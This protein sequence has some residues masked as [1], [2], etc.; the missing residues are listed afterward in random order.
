M[1]INRHATR[2]ILTVVGK[3]ELAGERAGG[4]AIG[5]SRMIGVAL[6]GSTRFARWRPVY[7]DQT[8]HPT[9]DAAM[10]RELLAR[11]C[12]LPSS[13]R[14]LLIVLTEYRHALHGLA[15]GQNTPA[16]SDEAAL[17]GV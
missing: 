16:D 10:A 14:A 6:R 4:P 11:T 12:E 5:R 1:R 9:Y 15:V 7:P 13:K 3:D 8:E 2:P 17:S